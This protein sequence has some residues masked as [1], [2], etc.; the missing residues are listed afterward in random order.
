MMRRQICRDHVF[1]LH[2][3]APTAAPGGGIIEAN[4]GGYLLATVHPRRSSAVH[5]FWQ[6]RLLARMD[7][8]KI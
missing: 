5:G 3:E 6:E 4:P 1:E 8:G 2:L 7:F